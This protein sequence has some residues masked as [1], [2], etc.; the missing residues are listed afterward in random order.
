MS[1]VIE[2]S[3]DS[4]Q[5]VR[6]GDGQNS[7]TIPIKVYQD[8]YHQITGRTEKIKKTSDEN[9][10]IGMQEIEQL[11]HKIIQLCDVH[12]IVARNETV[13]IFHDQDRSEQ[14]TSFERFLA[15][16]SN[17][18]SPTINLVLKYNFAIVVAGRK[19]PQEYVVT[20]KLASR[21]ALIKKLKEDAPPFVPSHF[22]SAMAGD[23]AEV[24]VEYADYVV[25]RGF[26][27]A[28][29]EW[30]KGC[31]TDVE[32][33]PIKVLKRYSFLFPKA[34]GPLV[35]ASTLFYTLGYIEESQISALD[36]VYVTKLFSIVLVGLYI[37]V[38]FAVFAGK[39][40]E[41]SI[42]RYMP[43]S[44]LNLNRGDSKLINGFKGGKKIRWAEFVSG[45]ILTIILGIA[46]SKLA[47]LINF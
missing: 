16:N 9:L 43:T 40:I 13:S 46:S 30:V 23:V 7:P 3:D 26:V 20:I 22:F 39:L 10:L 21:V 5:S 33:K 24:K 32:P 8:I 38:T 18:A 28:F 2:H 34:F 12:K 25:A 14:F 27:E 44:Y 11:H 42:D 15:Y 19:N 37:L 31:E 47:T 6:V 36:A 29:E 41:S 35:A 17:S 4:A 1:E 45:S